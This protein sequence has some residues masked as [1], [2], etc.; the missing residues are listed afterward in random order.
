MLVR[1]GTCTASAL[2]RIL[3]LEIGK[4]ACQA[5]SA[6]IF[7]CEYPASLPTLATRFFIWCESWASTCGDKVARCAAYRL[8][9]YLA[10]CVGIPLNQHCSF[11][12]PQITRTL[13]IPSFFFILIHHCVVPLPL[14]WGRLFP[15][16]RY[17]YLVEVRL[18]GQA[19][20]MQVRWFAYSA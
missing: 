1:P 12:L 3:R 8:R 17:F 10:F 20:A 16:G 11:R 7:A 4:L 5:K 6:S 14:S 19:L 15:C 13:A 18:F 2:V 9:R